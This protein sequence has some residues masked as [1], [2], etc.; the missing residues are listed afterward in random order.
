LAWQVAIV[1]DQGESQETFHANLAILLGQMPVWA[2]A[3]DERVPGASE[4]RKQWDNCWYPEPGLTVA[5]PCCGDDRIAE[6]D[7]LIPTIQEHHYRMAAVRLFGTEASSALTES[8]ANLGFRPISGTTW[9][10]IGFARPLSEIEDVPVILFS[11]SDWKTENDFFDAFFSAVGAPDWHGRNFSALNDSI[12]AGRINKLE[13]P[14]RM[15]V[16]NLNTATTE[17]RKFMTDF[18]DLI[19]GLQANGCPVAIQIEQ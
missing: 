8:F 12:G 5:L 1:L 3:R 16:Q 4:L 15:V 11:A 2:I 6:V 17:V 18:A 14:Y 9:D 19:R 13:V 7:N 10:G